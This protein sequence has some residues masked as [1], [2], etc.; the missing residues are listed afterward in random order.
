MIDDQIPKTAINEELL[1]RLKEEVVL[2]L[3]DKIQKEKKALVTSAVPLTN[4]EKESLKN[5]LSRQVER[6]IEIEN[7][8]DKKL[9]G[10]FKIVL[11]DW[12]YDA[13]LAYLFQS[14]KEN[15]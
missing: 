12:K 9:L 1:S 10:G 11:G 6:V 15:L 14:L 13:S 8:V 7:L 4:E 5:I 2:E 3:A